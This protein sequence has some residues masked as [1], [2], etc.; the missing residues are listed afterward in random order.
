MCDCNEQNMNHQ[1]IQI[2][3]LTCKARVFYAGGAIVGLFKGN[4]FGSK[5]KGV[6][7]PNFSSLY[8]F[9]VCLEYV[10]EL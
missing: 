6:E 8:V 2:I 10:I 4:D 5:T 3:S 1:V 7:N 9:P